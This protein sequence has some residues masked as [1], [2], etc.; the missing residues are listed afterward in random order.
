MFFSTT[1]RFRTHF[2]AYLRVSGVILVIA[3]SYHMRHH[4]TS[5]TPVFLARTILTTPKP[6][7]PITRMHLSLLLRELPSILVPAPLKQS[8]PDSMSFKVRAVS[9]KAEA[10]NALNGTKKARQTHFSSGILVCGLLHL[11]LLR[12]CSSGS[13]VLNGFKPAFASHSM[14]IKISQKRGSLCSRSDASLV[15]EFEARACCEIRQHFLAH[16]HHS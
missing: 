5:L 6:P 2:K 15:G 10:S 4:A 3:A 9:S 13:R 8:G 11:L 7:R 1:S 14:S 16:F 12:F